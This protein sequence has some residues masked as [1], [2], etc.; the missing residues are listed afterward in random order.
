M[1]SF[2]GVYDCRRLPAQG[3]AYCVRLWNSCRLRD[4]QVNLI[5]W[6]PPTSCSL[7]YQLYPSQTGTGSSLRAHSTVG[8][9]TSHQYLAKTSSRMGR[10][11]GVLGSAGKFTFHKFSCWSEVASR[12]RCGQGWS[13]AG[14]WTEGM[15]CS[16]VWL[17]VCWHP[18]QALDESCAMASTEAFSLF[19]VVSFWFHLPAISNMLFFRMTQPGR[20]RVTL[21][22]AIQKPL[23]V[24]GWPTPPLWKMMDNS[25]VGMTTFPIY[26]KI[27][28]VPNHQPG[29][30]RW[31]RG[32]CEYLLASCTA[33]QHRLE[34]KRGSGALP[35]SKNP[36]I[37]QRGKVRGLANKKIVYISC[38]NK[39][40]LSHLGTYKNWSIMGHWQLN[41][42]LYI[43][44]IL[45]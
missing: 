33:S 39:K 38:A 20:Q 29:K 24:G 3:Q 4:W 2:D 30:S 1:A 26:G 16:A 6:Y 5:V 18:Y 28:H 45:I 15:A 34:L 31:D 10:L 37:F 44:I 42:V 22:M 7:L 41:L 36:E 17:R 11:R 13:R 8:H 14:G 27:R 43:L 21:Q 25:S 19:F 23:L 40:I 12:S 9:P 32:F 35:T